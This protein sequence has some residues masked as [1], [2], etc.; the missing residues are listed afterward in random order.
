MKLICVI[1][2]FLKKGEIHK[3]TDILKF[4][5]STLSQNRKEFTKTLF[6]KSHL[7]G[8]YHILGS[9]NGILLLEHNPT[10]FY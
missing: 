3:K 5:F 7:C 6:I 4:L 8:F 10:I 9:N 1:F 2:V